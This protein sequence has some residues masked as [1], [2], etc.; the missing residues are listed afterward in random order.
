[1]SGLAGIILFLTVLFLSWLVARGESLE[2]ALARFDREQ[3]ARRAELE[4]LLGVPRLGRFPIGEG[5]IRGA[6]AA[7]PVWSCPSCGS[8]PGTNIDC[9]RCLSG[10]D[11]RGEA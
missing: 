8:E 2:G 5:I 9:P 6:V 1:M 4:R 7:A 3:A 11:R 10:V